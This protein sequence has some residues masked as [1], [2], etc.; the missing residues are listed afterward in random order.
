ML[1]V[2]GMSVGTGAIKSAERERER[3]RE[4][5]IHYHPLVQ[6]SVYSFD[7]LMMYN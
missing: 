3:E 2:M 7:C 6:E 5:M 1:S 4:R